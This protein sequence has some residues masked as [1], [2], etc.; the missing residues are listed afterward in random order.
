MGIRLYGNNS[1][2]C[3]A[4]MLIASR[5]QPQCCSV[6][7]A[8]CTHRLA[9]M[10]V[11][12]FQVDNTLND[13]LGVNLMSPGSK[14]ERKRKQ[15][16]WDEIQETVVR[17]WSTGLQRRKEQAQSAAARNHQQMM[18]QAAAAQAG[19]GQAQAQGQAAAVNTLR[20]PL[21]ELGGRPAADGNAR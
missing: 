13:L 12:C 19:A 6:L 14:N 21:A 8:L 1:C 2:E 15:S 17:D 18:G 11:R 10:P 20:G 5:M 4:F 16:H 3:S 9:G 7:S